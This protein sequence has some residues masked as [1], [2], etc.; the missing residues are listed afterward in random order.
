[1]SGGVIT[2]D[3]VK[4]KLTPL[5]DSNITSLLCDHVNCSLANVQ[6]RTFVESLENLEVLHIKYGK[7]DYTKLMWIIRDVAQNSKTL[8]V[9]SV[10]GNSIGADNLK[11]LYQTL[12]KNPNITQVS[13]TDC[14]E[15]EN[16]SETNIDLLKTLVGLC[17]KDKPT[18][19]ISLM[20]EF[21]GIAISI[22]NCV[23]LEKVEQEVQLDLYATEENRE[24]FKSV[25]HILNG[26][27]MVIDNMKFEFELKGEV[28]YELLCVIKHACWRELSMQLEYT[29]E[30]CLK[31]IGTAA[32]SAVKMMNLH[33]TMPGKWDEA[34]FVWKCTEINKQELFNTYDLYDFCTICTNDD[35]N[36][37][38]CCRVSDEMTPVFLTMIQGYHIN[39]LETTSICCVPWSDITGFVSG[40]IYTDGENMA[41]LQRIDKEDFYGDV[42]NIEKHIV[43]FLKEISSRCHEIQTVDIHEYSL[44]KEAV[45]QLS[46]VIKSQTELTVVNLDVC[47]MSPDDIRTLSAGLK[48]HKGSLEELHLNNNTVGD[49]AGD[50]SKSLIN[51]DKLRVLYLRCC[52]MSP[53]DIRTLSA[54]LKQHKGSL[55][56]LH[57]NDNTVGDA[58][59]DL[60]KSLINHDKLRVLALGECE[61]SP[62]D[63]RTLSAGLKQHKG[64]LEELHLE[65]NTVSDAAGDLSK[66]LINHD[67]LRVL[68]LH[69]CEMSPDDIRTLSA[70]LK[71]QKGSLEKFFLYGNT[72]GDAAGDLAD[73]LKHHNKLKSLFLGLW[74]SV[75]SDMTNQMRKILPDTNIC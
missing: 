23:T 48:Q 25:L 42:G 27:T 37:V 20:L 70:G 56:E 47:S 30:E 15:Q 2:F 51:H 10:D 69:R 59:G 11:E 52:E 7:L 50:L 34:V 63:I 46:S 60:S 6:L 41:D 5:V 28:A 71:Q 3:Y 9:L 53:D 75:S 12:L 65:G 74:S 19:V 62:D 29:D 64:S 55:E 58:A 26:L 38:F 17:V 16:S 36:N 1:M 35:T 32:K 18:F 39:K 31:Q 66:S 44:P 49:A 45:M 54:G 8:E 24:K 43:G 33:L 21:I 40:D 14:F 73:S 4:N 67:K 13:I 68:Y 72:V 61:M 57:L 22:S